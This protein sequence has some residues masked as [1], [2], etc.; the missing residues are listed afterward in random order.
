M[1]Q[2]LKPKPETIQQQNAALKAKLARA[3]RLIAQLKAETSQLRAQISQLQRRSAS[4]QSTASFRTRSP[5]AQNRTVITGSETRLK[6]PQQASS[7]RSSRAVARRRSTARLRLLLGTLLSF[8]VGLTIT[9]A[10]SRQRQQQPV[11]PI[12]PSATLQPSSQPQLQASTAA[13]VLPKQTIDE[14]VYN[15]QPASLEASPALQAIV[16]GAVALAASKSLATEPL[17]ITL[18]DLKANMIAGYQKEKPRYPASVVKLFWLVICEA[19]LENSILQ[20]DPALSAD[21]TAMIVHSDN[22]AA[23]RIFDRI[24]QTTSGSQLSGEA[25]ATWLKNRLRM[26][27]F[28]RAAGYDGLSIS[29]KNY[30][31]YSLKLDGPDG[32]ELQMLDEQQQPIRSLVTSDQA[33]R[34]MYEIYSGKAISA[35]RSQEMIALLTRDLNPESWKKQPDNSIAGFLGESLPADLRF[36]SKVGM[37]TKARHEVAFIESKDGKVAYILAVFGADPTYSQ[38]SEI[39]PA[40]SNAV[41]TQMM[42]RSAH[43]EGMKKSEG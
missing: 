35:S 12:Q 19:Q 29:Q 7:G 30:P 39:L 41:Y 18:I 32:R 1:R 2:L 3:D 22:D 31:I 14:L 37:T 13:A 21:L 42:E 20:P 38:N 25:Y 24:T 4:P 26:N 10:F 8:A 27:Q 33:A 11:A 17:S 23:S 9:A 28:F 6:H 43:A 36:A 34:L 16:D 15:A 40:I 5:A